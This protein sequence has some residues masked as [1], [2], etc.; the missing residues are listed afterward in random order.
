M[1]AKPHN[2]AKA[3]SLLL[4]DTAHSPAHVRI[5]TESQIIFL[6][7][8]LEAEIKKNNV[9]SRVCSLIIHHTEILVLFSFY[10]N[11]RFS[12]IQFYCPKF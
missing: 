9:T 1:C 7:F 3:V 4:T 12:F 5:K 2:R 11:F 8:V 6:Q 10:S